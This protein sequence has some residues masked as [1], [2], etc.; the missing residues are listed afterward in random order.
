MH[1]HESDLV[2]I[3][4]FLEVAPTPYLAPPKHDYTLV[5]EPLGIVKFGS[6]LRPYLIQFLQWV[7]KY[8]DLVL[9]TWEMPN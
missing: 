3:S 7:T 4:E 1:I 6:K 8:F 2:G 9:W 5:L